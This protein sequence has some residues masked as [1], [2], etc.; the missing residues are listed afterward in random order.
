[1]NY[2]I[3]KYGVLKSKEIKKNKD[4]R[5]NAKKIN[6]V[7]STLCLH[8]RYCSRPKED[9]VAHMSYGV[10]RRIG[11]KSFRGPRIG[12]CNKRDTVIPI[13]IIPMNRG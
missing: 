9:V 2:S 8:A 11:Y 12:P 4:E 13:T 6:G 10:H 7:V 1:M 3:K 5:E